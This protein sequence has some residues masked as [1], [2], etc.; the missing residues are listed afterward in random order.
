[1]ATKIVELGTL[2][3]GDKF[4]CKPDLLCGG[5]DCV[6]ADESVCVKFTKLYAGNSAYCD[7]ATGKVFTA[8]GSNR[9]T[10]TTVDPK[11]YDLPVGTRFKLGISGRVARKLAGDKIVFEDRWTLTTV[12]PTDPETCEVLS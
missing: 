8:V 11:V 9:V 2:K 5:A 1:M 3:P 6:V 12:L 4:N 7:L 10:I